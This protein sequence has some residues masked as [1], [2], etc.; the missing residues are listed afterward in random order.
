M[1]KWEIMFDIKMERENNIE[2]ICE[3]CMIRLTKEF[4]TERKEEKDRKL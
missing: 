3:I 2:I 1:E 4:N